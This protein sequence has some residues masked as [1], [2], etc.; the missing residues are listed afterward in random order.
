MMAMSLH[1][2]DIGFH[3]VNQLNPVSGSALNTND[4]ALYEPQQYGP[5]F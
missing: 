3:W 1:L 5:S 4:Y 2:C